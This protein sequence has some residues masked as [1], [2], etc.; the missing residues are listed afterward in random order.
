MEGEIHIEIMHHLFWYQNMAFYCSAITR[1][2]V[3][4]EHQS[5]RPIGCCKHRKP[6]LQG[7]KY[8]TKPRP[9]GG[10]IRTEMTLS[11]RLQFRYHK[12]GGKLRME[13]TGQGED[14]T[15]ATEIKEDPEHINSLP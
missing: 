5:I 1:A 10:S 8:W 4:A 3:A 11:G 7:Q 12:S 9:L 6:R 14:Q 15:K 2:L 13:G